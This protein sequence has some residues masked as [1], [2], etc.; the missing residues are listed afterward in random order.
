[1]VAVSTLTSDCTRHPAVD[2]R[3]T[4]KRFEGFKA[5]ANWSYRSTAS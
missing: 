2:I 4:D 1:M 3:S 5:W